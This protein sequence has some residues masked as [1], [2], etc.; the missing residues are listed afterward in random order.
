MIG[1][2]KG[3]ATIGKFSK[4]SDQEKKVVLST[5]GTQI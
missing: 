4:N 3:G 1:N 2:L 5:T